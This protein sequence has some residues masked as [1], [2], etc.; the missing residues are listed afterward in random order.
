[1]DKSQKKMNGY[2]KAI[3]RRLNLPR[4]IKE[5][6]INDLASSIEGRR[7]AG[8]TDEEINRSLSWIQ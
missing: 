6:V 7:E 4:D 5:R 8:K 1:M 2:L 3:A